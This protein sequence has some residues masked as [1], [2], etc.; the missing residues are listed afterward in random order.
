MGPTRRSPLSRLLHLFVLN[1]PHPAAPRPRA[2]LMGRP[3]HPAGPDAEPM[4]ACSFRESSRGKD[5][6]ALRSHADRGFAA[7]DARPRRLS[8]ARIQSPSAAATLPLR[9]LDG[10]LHPEGEP[11]LATYQ[12]TWGFPLFLCAP[13][14]GGRRV[15]AGRRGSCNALPPTCRCWGS[16]MNEWSRTCHRTGRG[17][18][19][20]GGKPEPCGKQSTTVYIYPTPPSSSSR[21]RL[22]RRAHW[23]T[24]GPV[25][26]SAHYQPT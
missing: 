17:M 20:S 9:H 1:M 22:H 21:R 24:F 26:L 4:R 3:H 13:P 5:P 14:Q 15:E 19:A 16:S 12:P 11:L 10:C 18:S 25:A 2:R 23:A 6:A 7:I 8:A